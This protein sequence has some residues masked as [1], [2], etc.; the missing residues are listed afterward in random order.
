MTVY[1]TSLKISFQRQ[2]QFELQLLI[3]TE[4]TGMKGDTLKKK[5]LRGT[6]ADRKMRKIKDARAEA[7]CHGAVRFSN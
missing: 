1:I 3:Y 6:N 5:T 2:R 7:R 4:N